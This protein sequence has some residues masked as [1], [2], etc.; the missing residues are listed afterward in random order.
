MEM[1]RV[2]PK[3]H[4]MSSERRLSTDMEEI[5]TVI[6]SDGIDESVMSLVF[7]SSVFISSIIMWFAL[8]FKI[9]G[10]TWLGKTI[11]KMLIVNHYNLLLIE[12]LVNFF[13][14]KARSGQ[15]VLNIKSRKS[16]V[17]CVLNV[18]MCT[19]IYSGLRSSRKLT[20]Y[21]LFLSLICILNCQLI[22][23]RDTNDNYVKTMLLRVGNEVDVLL[24]SVEENQS[25][26]VSSHL[27][28]DRGFMSLRNVMQLK[29]YYNIAS[30]AITYMLVYYYLSVLK[31]LR[32]PSTTVLYSVI[33]IYMIQIKS[34]KMMSN[35]NSFLFKVESKHNIEIELKIGVKQLKWFPTR[36]L[37]LSIN[38]TF[39]ANVMWSIMFWITNGCEYRE[40]GHCEVLCACINCGLYEDSICH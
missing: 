39:F 29:L 2:L 24:D 34:F 7:F 21:V 26:I 38:I 30:S 11:G 25:I 36:E 33:S 3:V 28:Q 35:L 17:C 4:R 9:D 19:V 18:I 12:Y 10:A 31:N 1:K 13:F 6:L 16:L 40:N 23:E 20:E 15:Q 8:E 32:D 14:R 27:R 37:S 5:R 22:M